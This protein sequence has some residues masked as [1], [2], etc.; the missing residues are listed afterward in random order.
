VAPRCRSH[1]FFNPLCVKPREGEAGGGQQ[2]GG[3]RCVVVDGRAVPL[4]RTQLQ[5]FTSVYA[6]LG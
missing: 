2:G 1:R 5:G 3:P 6:A 4:D